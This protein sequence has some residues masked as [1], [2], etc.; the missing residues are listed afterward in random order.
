MFKNQFPKQQ[1]LPNPF[2]LVYE[3]FRVPPDSQ[4]LICKM[5]RYQ[6]S[7]THSILEAKVFEIKKSS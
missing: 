1:P 4:S 7:E 3:I 5:K 2:P 6:K